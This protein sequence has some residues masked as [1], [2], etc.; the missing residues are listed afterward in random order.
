MHS[1]I[2]FMMTHTKKWPSWT[3]AEPVEKQI[4]LSYYMSRLQDIPSDMPVVVTL[5]PATEVRQGTMFYQTDYEH[6]RFSLAT[7]EAQNTLEQVQGE[8]HT[9]FAGA[10]LGHGF[11]EDGL[12]SAVAVAQSLGADVPWRIDEV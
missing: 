9:Y 8:R 4:E 12:R 5:N 7:D 11:H 2:S 6:P 1:D 10:W 3:Y